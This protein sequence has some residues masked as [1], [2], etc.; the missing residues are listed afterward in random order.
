M[1]QNAGSKAAPGGFRLRL[2]SLGKGPQIVACMLVVA[3]LVAMAIEPTRQLLTQRQRVAAMDDDLSR[4]QA[5]N[6]RLE[7][8]ITRLQDPDYLEQR[9]REQSGLVLPG[10]TG[11]V[12]MQ[13]SRTA[14]QKHR[15]QRADKVAP[16]PPEPGLVESFLD[17]VGFL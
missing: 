6:E 7:D 10:E 3:L 17:F 11:V 5:Q 16:A 9:A 4:L 1:A 8:R 13:P 15:K 2:P 14:E 12:V